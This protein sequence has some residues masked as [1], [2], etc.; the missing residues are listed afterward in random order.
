MN[1]E[2]SEQMLNRMYE[3]LQKEQMKLMNDIIVQ[4]KLINFLEIQQRQKRN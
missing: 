3:D 4:Q 2:I 1:A